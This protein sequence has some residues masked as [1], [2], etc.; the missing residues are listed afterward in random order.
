[1]TVDIK[2][3]FK[4][5]L[6]CAAALL[7]LAACQQQQTQTTRSD[8]DN[9]EAAK[10]V[11]Q[12]AYN[13]IDAANARD[14]DAMMKH[15]SANKDDVFYGPG[16]TADGIHGG[17]EYVK[18]I[19]TLFDNIKDFKST[20]NKESSR[21][22]VSGDLGYG[23]LT[24]YNEVTDVEGN[25]G[26][27][28]WRWNYV[29]RNQGGNWKVVGENFAFIRATDGA[30]AFTARSRSKACLASISVEVRMPDLDLEMI[31]K[32]PVRWY[33]QVETIP[34]VNYT[35]S[36]SLTPTPL[37]SEGR[38]VGTLES[39]IVKFREIVEHVDLHGV[40]PNATAAIDPN[41]Q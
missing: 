27:S 9:K 16:P 41:R 14:M 36:V 13:I 32:E 31:T 8:E 28:S 2:R 17:G 38:Q 18:A 21:V 7:L 1:M 24:G 29:A 33:S 39:G 20:P 34:P 30:E 11:A 15:Y 4:M 22:I 23:S 25:S 35:A 6:V 40:E 12:V 3:R 5:T 10:A 37:V 26:A 19:F